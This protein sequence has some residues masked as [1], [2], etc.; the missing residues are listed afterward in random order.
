VRSAAPVP[1]LAPGFLASGTA[2]LL[3]TS[4]DDWPGVKETKLS[5]PALPDYPNVRVAD[6]AWCA[7]VAVVA[8]VVAAGA[9]RAAVEG[10]HRVTKVPPVALLCGA[11]AVV[12]L[13]AVLF[14]AIT[15]APT[16]LV[17]FSG[18]DALAPLIAE[19]SAGV[20]V[21]V[22]VAKGL[23]YV[24]S[25][26][27][28]FRGGPTFPAI[29]LGVAVGVLASLVLPGL[30]LTPAVIAGLAAGASAG[31]ELAF[32]GALI[33]ALLAGATA[34][35]TIPIAVIATMI[36]WLVAQAAKRRQQAAAPTAA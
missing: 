6:V 11:G 16:S 23:A 27:A 29:A 1:A 24:I 7:L 33:A 14:R 20:L 22:V 4:L 30:D 9:R 32:F 10:S 31:L 18:E 13:V 15:D 28:G 5:L 26:T 17:L 35:E 2:T 3:F 34:A 19:T 12:G 21:A 8:G 25:L 36:G